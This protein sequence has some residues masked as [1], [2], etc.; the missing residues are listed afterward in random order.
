MLAS[1]SRFLCRAV[2]DLSDRGIKIGGSL[3]GRSG[4]MRRALRG[5]DQ[6]SLPGPYASRYGWDHFGAI[7]LFAPEQSTCKVL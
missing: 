3:S 6:S 2:F 4:A 1:D 7:E 5:E